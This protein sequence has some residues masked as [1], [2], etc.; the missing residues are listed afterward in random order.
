MQLNF[1]ERMHKVSGV[2]EGNRKKTTNTSVKKDKLLFCSC[3][4]IPGAQTVAAE[5]YAAARLLDDAVR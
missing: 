2:Y 3:T 5:M 1:L 4:H